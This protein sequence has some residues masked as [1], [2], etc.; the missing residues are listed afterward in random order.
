MTYWPGGGGGGST[1]PA[2]NF[3]N[4]QINRNSAFATP[5]SDSL[6]FT[7]G[8]DIKGYVNVSATSTTGIQFGGT[9]RI[10]NDGSR[11]RIIPSGGE[12]QFYTAGT[13]NNIQVFN[14]S[15][16]NS[17]VVNGQTGQIYRSSDGLQIQTTGNVGIGG[18]V[19]T[20]STARLHIS[21]G[22][23]TASTAPFKLTVSGAVLLTTP[24]SGATEV[25]VDSIYYTGNNATR[26]RLA[27]ATEI[28]SFST[29]QGTD[30]ASVAGAIVL[31][32]G[33][34]IFEITGTNAITLI[35]NVRW[36]NGSEVTLIFTSTAT[37]TDGTANSGTD[38]GMELAGNANFS[39]SADDVLTLVLTEIGGTQRWREK[40]RSVN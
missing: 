35:S 9:T 12:V 16:S 30:V 34:N 13:G 6:T 28:G 32:S 4:V 14:S 27:Y 38:I 8:L 21:A 11:M 18:G 1:S 5:G 33:G 17:V 23:A 20:S 3:G 36:Q 37:L 25:L 31:G 29:K 7:A 24:E 39:A 40:S 15:G 19:G 22:T 2:G 10:Y 26:N